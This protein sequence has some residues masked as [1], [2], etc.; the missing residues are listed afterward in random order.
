M[1]Q[2]KRPTR[3]QKKAV[4]AAGLNPANWLVF[5]NLNGEL[6]LVHREVGTTK[7]IPSNN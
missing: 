4:I 5:K 7:V 2:G 1:K 6:H 3:N